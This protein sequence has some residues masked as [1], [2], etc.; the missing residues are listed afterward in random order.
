MKDIYELDYQSKLDIY[1]TQKAIKFV[2]DTFQVS[3]AKK[4]DL[5]RVSAP[6]FVRKNS[7]L[8]D[9]LSGVEKP[10][11]FVLSDDEIEI[12]HS[13]AK[14]KRYALKKYKLFQKEL[15]NWRRKNDTSS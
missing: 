7:G 4:L 3:L 10:V 13:L 8:N 15:R 1:T 12:V 2:K 11:N 6:M 14:W 5:L 9:G